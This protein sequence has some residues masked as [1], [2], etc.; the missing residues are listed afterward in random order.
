MLLREQNTQLEAMKHANLNRTVEKLGSYPK[1]SAKQY[2]SMPNM[3]YAKFS[4][5]NRI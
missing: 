5:K 1:A 2:V 4:H 3:K